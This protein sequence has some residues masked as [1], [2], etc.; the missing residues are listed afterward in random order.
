M[1]IAAPATAHP[2]GN[3][4]VNAAAAIMVSAGQIRVDYALDLAEIPAFQARR[5]IDADR[6]GAL[7][8]SELDA[9]ASRQA[10]RLLTG[11]RLDIDG[12]PIGLE[13][14]EARAGTSPGQGGLE[15]LRLDASYIGAAPRSGEVRAEDRNDSGRLGWR[16][17]TAAGT[18][19]LAV[20]SSSVPASSPSA[21][22]RAYPEDSLASPPVVRVAVF[23]YGPGEQPASGLSQPTRTNPTAGSSGLG[24]FVSRDSL[25]FWSVVLALLLALGVGA[26]HALAPG[27]G[28][29]VT[30]A[31]LAGGAARARDAI[32]AG[33]AVAVMHTSSVLALA[34]ILVFASRAFPSERV[35]PWLGILAGAAAAVLGAVQLA[36]RV[37]HHHRHDGHR[38]DTSGVSRPGLAAL[39]MS[40]GLLP[41]PT[42]V[43]VLVASFTL[44][45]AAF[46][47]ALV[48][49]FGI[50]LAAA[51]TV[52]GLVAIRARDVMTRH[53]STRFA[54]T[55]PVAGAGAILTMGVVVAARSIGQL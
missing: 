22:L 37:R 34:L 4:T 36:G 24:S 47:L 10:E 7:G 11:L 55:I 26:L 31:Y 41:S 23:S 52:V 3:F 38:H 45:R 14:L 15:I 35:Y 50:G 42:A 12:S 54:G 40:G 51:L 6:D 13:P 2:L 30:A 46:G 19:G 25:G 17:I 49:A 32:G 5:A 29:T 20:T 33:V 9:W 48:T 28:K 27:H 43:L 16:E 18:G 44:G 53:L 8:P 1:W 39:A 21:N